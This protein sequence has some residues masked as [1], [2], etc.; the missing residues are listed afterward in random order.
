MEQ[1]LIP[2][3]NVHDWKTEL[4]KVPHTSGHRHDYCLTLSKTVKNPI[5]LYAASDQDNR[6]VCPIQERFYNGTT[7]IVSIYGNSGFTGKGAFKDFEEQWRSFMK[8][9]GYVCAY[10]ALNRRKPRNE[11]F[12]PG[13]LFSQNTYYTLDLTQPIDDLS[14]FLTKAQKQRPENWLSPDVEIVTDQ[15]I[16]RPAFLELYPDFVESIGAA[17]SY[18]FSEQTLT[19]LME[20]P[21]ILLVGL[22]D[23]AGVY[24]VHLYLQHGDTAEW[25]LNAAKPGRKKGSRAIIWNSIQELKKR[26]ATFL[27]LGAG[28]KEGD[29]IARFKSRLATSKHPLLSLKFIFDEPRYT[30]LCENTGCSPSLDGFFPPYQ[31][32]SRFS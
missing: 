23:E 22:E 4:E 10:I 28:V 13:T 1:R 24:M 19:G 31:K 9:R 16:L 14:N 6:L 8:D 11:L 21:G 29:S 26:G 7:D 32:P 12:S 18:H 20:L 5:F 3:S 25:F 30:E 15:I 2:L 27:D 17:S